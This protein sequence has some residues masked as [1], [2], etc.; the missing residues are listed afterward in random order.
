MFKA[1]V[2]RANGTPW[3]PTGMTSKKWLDVPIRE[4]RIADL[5]ATQDGVYF[6]PLMTD[7]VTRPVGGDP[8]PHVIHWHGQLYLEDG[9]HRATRA[10]I[11]AQPT[12]HA[13][14]LDL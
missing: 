9:H 5:I 6:A 4:V 7:D 14:V 13:R 1:T 3:P 10:I 8:H 12:I 11:R 2:S